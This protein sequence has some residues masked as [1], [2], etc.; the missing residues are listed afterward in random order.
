MNN[1]YSKFTQNLT[2]CTI[3]LQKGILMSRIPS[4][5][6]PSVQFRLQE[7]M[8]NAGFAQ[9][10]WDE[11]SDYCKS[12]NAN[13]NHCLTFNHVREQLANA[14]SNSLM[15]KIDKSFGGFIDRME[16]AIEDAR[17]G[18]N[19]VFNNKSDQAKVNPEAD[20][21][22]GQEFRQMVENGDIIPAEIMERME[23]IVGNT[24]HLMHVAP[25]E[26]DDY[27][28]I[29]EDGQA[30]WQAFQTVAN[31]PKEFGLTSRAPTL[32]EAETNYGYVYNN[33][34]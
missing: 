20:R 24:A 2:F 34:M 7:D 23:Y 1:Y 8:A 19:D 11:Y 13:P 18:L 14:H 16:Q 26:R 12:E 17:V 30:A 15:G 27:A 32:D 3:M 5:L 29:L 10:Q 33:S 25:S 6:N 31:N 28:Q 4:I 21:E 22:F 9:D